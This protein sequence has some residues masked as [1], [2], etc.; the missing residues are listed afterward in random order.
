MNFAKLLSRL[1]GE[2]PILNRHNN[3][4]L[5][6][7]LMECVADASW[8]FNE[9]AMTEY[10]ALPDHRKFGALPGPGGSGVRD[11]LACGDHY[12]RLWCSDVK[13]KVLTTMPPQRRISSLPTAKNQ[14]AEILEA[15]H[16]EELQ[17]SVRALIPRPEFCPTTNPLCAAGS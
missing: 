4:E 17:G 16:G 5:T 8:H 7:K 1:N 9:Q 14:P 11:F 6:E 10:N 2:R 13:T 3:D 12:H 15:K